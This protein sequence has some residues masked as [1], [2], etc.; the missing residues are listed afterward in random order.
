MADNQQPIDSNDSAN[1]F[2]EFYNRCCL[3]L[4]KIGPTPT[5][6]DGMRAILARASLLWEN[7]KVGLSD[8]LT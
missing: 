2:P 3:D 6:I 7:G 1:D 5:R 4:S 8:A